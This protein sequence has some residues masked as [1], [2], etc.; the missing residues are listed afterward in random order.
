MRLSAGIQVKLGLHWS[1]DLSSGYV[2]DRFFAVGN[3]A[4]LN[5]PDRI[6]VAPGPFLVAEI[7]DRSQPSAM[8]FRIRSR[9][10]IGGVGGWR[11]AFRCIRCMGED[12]LQ[13][14]CV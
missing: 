13:G 10:H 5:S 6:D 9:Q 4:A 14:V 3:S 12:A 11:W 2:F 7:A 1:F 8:P